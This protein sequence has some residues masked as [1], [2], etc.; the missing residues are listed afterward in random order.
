[1]NIL[2][3]LDGS[4][5]SIAAVEEVIKRPWPENTFIKGVYIV[6]PFHT[7]RGVWHANYVPVA[8]KV[9]EELL[10]AGKCLI[11][12]P[13]DKLKARFGEEN[14]SCEVH[15]GYTADRI[16]ELAEA[17]PAD[18]IVVGSHGRK[19]I[20][21]FLLGSVSQSIVTTQRPRIINN[22]NGSAAS[23][24]RDDPAVSAWHKRRLL[25]LRI[26]PL[27][28]RFSSRVTARQFSLLAV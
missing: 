27:R 26:R 2:I 17:W 22:W 14:V 8:L 11:E 4:P 7:A 18:L 6:E 28:Q 16:L 3:A 9:Q 21:R 23:T 12:E 13:A 20:T 19:G 15:E 25:Q 1:M 5:Y 24:K 10:E